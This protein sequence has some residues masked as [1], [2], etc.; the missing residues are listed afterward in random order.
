MHSDSIP[1]SMSKSRATT[2]Q[3]YYATYSVQS[4]FN[5]IWSLASLRHVIFLSCVL[6]LGTCW[7]I[8]GVSSLICR[9][10]PVCLPALRYAIHGSKHECIIM[11]HISPL[12]SDSIRRTYSGKVTTSS[13]GVWSLLCVT[14]M[15]S[16]CRAQ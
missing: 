15:Y 7:E 14:L 1:E 11:K 16:W 2:L 4:A 3:H 10:D 12:A 9:V 6:N 13:L 8:T 5:I